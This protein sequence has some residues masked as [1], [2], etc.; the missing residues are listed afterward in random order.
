MIR[1]RGGI[2]AENEAG[3]GGVVEGPNS[4]Q[5]PSLEIRSIAADDHELI[6]LIAERMRQTL[7][8]VLGSERGQ[9]MYSIEW[10][11][12]RVMQHLDGRYVA[13]VWGVFLMEELIAHTILRK[14]SEESG[15]EY[16]LFSTFYVLP[17]HRSSGVFDLLVQ[18]G[19][20]WMR[21]LGLDHART[22]T[23]VDNSRLHRA[24]ARHG[25]AEIFQSGEMVALG[26]RL[27]G[28][29]DLKART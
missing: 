28:E 12:D 17:A 15:D 7:I 14:E 8:E 13:A 5:A 19:E 10:L 2:L 18:K 20:S 9:S 26:K 25:Y 23:A 22:N 3:G 11:R 21:S 6:K 24:M 16:G 1:S 4:R 27:D 29:A